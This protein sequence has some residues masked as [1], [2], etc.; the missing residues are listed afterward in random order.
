MTNKQLNAVRCA[1]GDLAGAYQAYKQGDLN[2]HDW[3]NHLASIDELAEQ[4]DLEDE[5]PEL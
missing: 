2:I 1:L 5:V 4:F 3:E